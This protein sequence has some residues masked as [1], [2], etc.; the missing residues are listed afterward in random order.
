MVSLVGIKP[1]GRGHAAARGSRLTSAQQDAWK[2]RDKKARQ[3]AALRAAL[4]AGERLWSTTQATPA[5]RAAI[6]AIAHELGRA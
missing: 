6:L 3:N 1:R 2:V 5:E 4:G